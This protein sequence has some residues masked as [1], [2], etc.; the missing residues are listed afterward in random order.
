MHSFAVQAIESN[1]KVTLPDDL[2]ASLA[3]G[4]V[5]CH[6]VNTLK[7]GTIV[8]I[9]IPSAGVVSGATAEIERVVTYWARLG[10]SWINMNSYLDHSRIR[11]TYPPKA[12]PYPTQPNPTQPKPT[13]NQPNPTQAKPTQT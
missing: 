12:Y 5:L 8:S 1:L 4:V 10:S 13:P 9:H 6:L 7:K 2:P 3:D 11:G